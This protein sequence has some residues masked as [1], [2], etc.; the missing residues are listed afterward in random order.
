MPGHAASD[1]PPARLPW[2]R[3]RPRWRPAELPIASCRCGLR[4][5]FLA[6]ARSCCR[7][8]VRRSAVRRLF[9]PADAASICAPFGRRGAGQCDQFC[10]RGAVENARPGGARRVF[11]GQRRLQAFLHQELAGPARRCRCWCPAPRQSGCHSSPRPHPRRPPSAGSAPS[12][13]WAACFSP[14]QLVE[15]IAFLRAELDHVFL[16][17]NLFRGHE[18]PP[19]LRRQRVRDPPQNQ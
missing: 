11:A 2:R 13:A 4:T 18:S 3:Q 14:D 6:S 10:F 1:R 12:A 5:F 15:P 9:P 7:W 16:D 19:S 8:R 17:G